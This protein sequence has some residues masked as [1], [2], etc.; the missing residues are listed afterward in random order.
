MRIVFPQRSGRYVVQTIS[1][2]LS[3]RDV[4]GKTV[5]GFVIWAPIVNS[6]STIKHKI[7]S[8]PHT[9]SYYVIVYTE[10]KYI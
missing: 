10:S 3:T 2:Q 7:K 9:L 4:M 5:L 1:G 8:N 6:V